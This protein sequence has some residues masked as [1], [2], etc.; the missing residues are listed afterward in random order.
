MAV[1]D[2]EDKLDKIYNMFNNANATGASYELFT[3][4]DK[5][6]QRI[7]KGN[8]ANIPNQVTHYPAIYI[9]L[10]SKETEFS[11]IMKSGGRYKCEINW[12]VYG[13]VFKAPGSNNSDQQVRY[14]AEN[15]EEVVRRNITLSGLSDNLY[16]FIDTTEFAGLEEDGIY[17]SAVRLN[18]RTVH[19]Y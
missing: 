19:L 8:P 4:M 3:N 18:L 11:D 15:I 13:F 2:Y 14:L 16:N 7:V 5:P 12:D 10:N 6:I 1:I 9:N 17:L